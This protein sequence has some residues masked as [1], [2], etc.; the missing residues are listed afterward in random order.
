VELRSEGNGDPQRNA[1]TAK[2][3]DAGAD[4]DCSAAP[5][6]ECGPDGNVWRLDACGN[7]TDIVER[8]A[9]WHG[10]CRDAQCICLPGWAGATCDRCVVFVDANAAPE[11]DG[12]SWASALTHVPPAIEAA[13]ARVDP[14]TKV[15]RCEVWVARG[16]YTPTDG[17]D[18]NATM[19]LRAGVDVY[20]GFA[21]NERV[22]ED[23]DLGAGE[24]ILSGDI[25]AANVPD[26]NSRH[27]VTSANDATL[28]GF[29]IVAGNAP[30]FDGSV[31][32]DHCGAGILADGVDLRLRNATLRD[33]AAEKGAALCL[34][35]A[36][37]VLD[38][39]IFEHNHANYLGPVFISESDAT[40]SNVTVSDNDSSAWAVGVY[41]E[42]SSVA[43]KTAEFGRNSGGEGALHVEDSTVT[44]EDGTF[45]DN[46]STY[47]EDRAGGGIL[48]RDSEIDVARCKMTNNR[49]GGGGGIC[50]ISGRLHVE[51]C[52]FEGN[53]ATGGGGGA[54]SI[55]N[56]S[57]DVLR[58][59]FSKHD[60][61]GYGGAIFIE[62]SNQGTA[63]LR[64]EG[65]SFTDNIA[66]GSG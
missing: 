46:V 7:R 6:E 66:R 25:G 45:H 48:A 60:V 21:G 19:T 27:V 56:A 15:A 33:N 17:T 24:T 55:Q 42:R 39:V 28:D 53:Q 49:A 52:A 8:C 32:D 23:R 43:I 2:P 38:G 54:L 10:D 41:V 12:T 57:V 50:A 13:A 59:T 34:H 65:S 44:V 62:T 3:G 4:V 63:S 37:A 35:E 1:G 36:S 31:L 30:T 18:E 16:T 51:D 9:E 29:T 64:V 47:Q 40:V 11:G 61:G 14:A 5:T 26:D 20:G 22:L 58:S